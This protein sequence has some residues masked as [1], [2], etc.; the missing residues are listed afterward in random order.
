LSGEQVALETL[1]NNRALKGDRVVGEMYRLLDIDNQEHIIL[2]SASPIYNADGQLSGA[3]VLWHDIT[4]RVQAEEHARETNARLEVQRRLIEQREQERLQIAR[5]LHDGPVQ[6][7]L[8]AMYALQGMLSDDET[9]NIADGLRSIAETLR[10]QAAE[11]RD[12]AGNLRPPALSKFGL[13][14]AIRSHA[15]SFQ[16]KHPE[17]QIT[18][19]ATQEGSLLPEEMRLALFRIYQEAMRNIARHSPK[20]NVTIRFEKDDR[21]ARLEISD[22]GPGFEVPKD[23]LALARA[24]H[25]G[26]VGMR[27]RAEAIGGQLEITA[28]PGWGTRIRA[29]VP[30]KDQG[31]D[32]QQ[33][34]SQRIL[35]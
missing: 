18:M 2:A 33:G 30:L 35:S 9:S 5:D 7:L 20:A 19:E 25:L 32:S 22:D 4:E 8:G 17:I 29:T 14:R 16:Q 15:E 31:Q 1:P 24:G 13:E 28:A 12:Y 10:Q 27:E 11:L 21:E 26:L 23:W 6:E 3:L 34:S